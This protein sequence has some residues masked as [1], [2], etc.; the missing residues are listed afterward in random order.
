MTDI[1]DG[2]VCGVDGCA[3]GASERSETM[4]S[5][6]ATLPIEVISDAI[7]PWCWI[8]K[9]RLDRAI[10]A[11]SP[12]IRASVT[13][14]PFELN[15]GMPKTGMDRHTYRSAKFGSWQHSQAFDT[16][17]AAAGRSEGLI[18]NHDRIERTPNTIEAHRLIWL[19]GEQG[20]QDVV[21]E[22]LFAA[23]FYE[24]RDVGDPSVLADVGVS[25]GLDHS[26]ILAM[27]ASDEGQTEVQ[28]ELRRAVSLG[29]SG[30]PAVLARWRF[31]VHGGNS[32]RADGKPNCATQPA[33]SGA[34]SM[35][36]I[37]VAG[38]SIGGLCAGIALH[39]AGFDV[40]VY[41]RTSGPMETRGAGIVVQGE[42]TD[43][44]RTY[45]ARALPMTS[46]SVRRYLN[47]EGGDGE[48]QRAPQDFTSWEAI[49]RTLS[50]AFPS[51]RYHRGAMLISFGNSDGA[52]QAN[53]EG[54]GMVE[55]DV[56]VAADGAQSSTRRRLLPDLSSI[57]AG[58]VA[59]RGTLGEADAPPE[60]VRF[61]DNAFTFSDAR[62]PGH[63]LA[64]F[65]PGEG[66]DA[67]PGMRRLNWVWYVGVREA[68]LPRLLI[69]RDGRQ[70][71]ASLPFGGTADS[72]IRDLRDLARRE[73]HPMLAA[74]VAATPQP[75]L[76]TIVDI[77]PTRTVFGRV[78]LLGDA[79]FVVRPHTAGATA[80]AA[81]DATT[82]ARALKRAGRNIDAGMS[83]FEATQIEFGRGLVNY[84]VLLGRRWAA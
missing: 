70:H 40:Q 21:V 84:G 50:A 24:G 12:D 64:Y 75:F 46:C 47:P 35:L 56:L 37:A 7:C 36:R 48:V 73:V 10:T 25:A 27:L 45:G 30:V 53:I 41:E 52:V 62:S 18:F 4:F 29:V 9:R 11:L 28:S 66:G 15:P 44:L 61:F 19:A 78:C 22:K 54:H 83:G 5:A 57:Y 17:V 43:L 65:I 39:G 81:R 3:P 1:V 42:L 79:A 69:D 33:M 55:A 60:L 72:A 58:Y 38:G 51:E 67:S 74:L 8:A 80:K 14:R 20:E 59:W 6:R 32:R 68:D 71:H 76:Q 31:P 26:R 34:E 77:A 63:I 2:T 49:Y 23:Y 16:Q 82:L 13:W